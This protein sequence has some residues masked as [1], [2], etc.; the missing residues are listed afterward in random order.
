MTVFL[1]APKNPFAEYNHRDAFALDD[2][3]DIQFF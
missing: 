3:F 2:I 1:T